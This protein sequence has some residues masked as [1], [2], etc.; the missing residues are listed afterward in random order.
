[1]DD[2]RGRR[3]YGPSYQQSGSGR[4]TQPMGP[5]ASERYAQPSPT[6][7]R[8]DLTR[9]PPNRPYMPGYSDY[10]YHEPQYAPPPALSSSAMQGVELQ[11]P[12]A[13]TNETS[14]S[15]QMQAPQ[16]YGSYGQNIILPPGPSPSVYDTVPHYQQHQAAAVLSSQFAVPQFI[17]PTEHSPVGMPVPQRQYMVSQPEQVTFG[18]T[19]PS[20][21]PPAHSQTYVA[22]AG[23]YASSEQQQQEQEAEEAAAHQQS[24]NA[25]LRRCREH[26]QST[27]ALLQ[28]GRVSDAS[29]KIMELSRWLLSSVAAL[30]KKHPTNSAHRD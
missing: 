15:S 14:R 26:M 11:Y 22:P 19:L 30:G 28:V 2:E 13:Y 16:Q 4:A 6:A 29:Q 9:P 24:L 27:F 21:R 7:P 23:Q 17:P 8:S 3:Q 1:M 10:T 5:P 18:H 20:S 25:T 12:A